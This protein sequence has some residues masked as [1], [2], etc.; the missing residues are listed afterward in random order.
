MDVTE[1]GHISFILK[2]TI[3]NP[4]QCEVLDWNLR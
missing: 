1:N 2:V 3:Q 4:T